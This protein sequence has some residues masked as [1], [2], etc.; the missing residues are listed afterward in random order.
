MRCRQHRRDELVS[1][2]QQ[3]GE[4]WAARLVGQEV[5]VLVEGYN[6][7]GWLIGRTQWD[8][9]DV[10]G[11]KG[12]GGVDARPVEV[13]ARS[14]CAQPYQSTITP[15]SSCAYPCPIWKRL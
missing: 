15:P 8:A 4:R 9:P 10:V 5:E 1:L 12:W 13:C 3:I 7:D 6:E 14:A 11:W 2:Q